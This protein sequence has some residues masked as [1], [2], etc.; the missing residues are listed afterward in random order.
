VG[1][2]GIIGNTMKKN[3]RLK[4]VKTS[5][6][7]TLIEKA[8]NAGV[9]QGLSRAAKIAAEHGKGYE[10]EGKELDLLLSKGSKSTRA[11]PEAVTRYLHIAHECKCIAAAITEQILE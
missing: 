2:F 10:S 9:A 4:K 1:I 6:R 3:G 8:F 5:L 7:P 11:T